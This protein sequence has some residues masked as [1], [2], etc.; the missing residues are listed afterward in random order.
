MVG[1]SECTCAT[2]GLRGHR[3][4]FLLPL[5]QDDHMFSGL[6]QYKLLFSISGGQRFKMAL[7]G[8]KHGDI[9]AVFLLETL[10]E[11]L[12]FPFCGF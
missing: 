12:F 3:I 1:E 9:R 10:G 7:V 5:S 11:N 6:K 8:L 2:S 4:D